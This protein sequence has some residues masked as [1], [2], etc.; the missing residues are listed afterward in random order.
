MSS[1][2]APPETARTQAPAQRSWLAVRWRQLRNPP[3]PLL[4]AVVA[5]VA[6]AAVGAVVLVAYDLAVSRDVSLP[7][8]DL[9]ALAAAAFVLLVV[10]SGSA[11]T[12]LWVDL[13]SGAAPVPRRSPWAAVLGFFASLPVAYLALVVSFQ[14]IRPLLA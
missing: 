7:G 9:R 10:V 8:G 3:P 4:R 6:V 11:L 1:S 2:T 14:I 13:P 12:Y 5:N